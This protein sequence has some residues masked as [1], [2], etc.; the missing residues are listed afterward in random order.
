[1]LYEARNPIFSKPRR[2]S[3]SC[4][5]SWNAATAGRARRALGRD[6]VVLLVAQRQKA[7]S[8][9][10][11]DRLDRDAPIRATLSDRRDDR[12]MRLRF[13]QE[14]ARFRAIEQAI[15]QHARAAAAIAVRQ[16]A[17]RVCDGRRDRLSDGLLLEPQITGAKHDSLA[18]A[19]TG[20]EC[21]RVIEKWPVVFPGL[22][23]EQ[24]NPG[25]IALAAFGGF[26]SRGAA[27]E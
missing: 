9:F 7:Q 19:I 10:A 21:E 25:Q 2:T 5:N 12:R 11:R 18:S 24:M 1:M 26:E 20:H 15:D 23:I 3:A 14:P 6:E 16:H 4:S 13:G 17:R 8:L 22:G 27:D